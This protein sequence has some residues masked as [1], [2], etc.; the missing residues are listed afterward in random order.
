M[1]IRNF[2]FVEVNDLHLHKQSWVSFFTWKA[3]RLSLITVLCVSSY[4]PHNLFNATK[5]HYSSKVLTGRVCTLTHIL[6]RATYYTADSVTVVTKQ[7]KQL[8]NFKILD[9]N[10]ERL[11][12]KCTITWQRPNNETQWESQE[13]CIQ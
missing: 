11:G 2:G 9:K 1:E 7:Q 6:S 10:R 5:F 13:E 8:I 4:Y 3:L 12:A